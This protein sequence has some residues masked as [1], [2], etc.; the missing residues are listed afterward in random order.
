MITSEWIT[1][2]WE[3]KGNIEMNYIE[4][5][6]EALKAEFLGKLEAL[7]KEAEAQKKQEEPKPWKPKDGEDYF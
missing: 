1:N 2:K 4:K 6:L 5:K 7:R 3:E